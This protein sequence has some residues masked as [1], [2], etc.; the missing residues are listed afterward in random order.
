MSYGGS[1]SKRGEWL[2]MTPGKVLLGQPDRDEAAAKWLLETVGMPEK[3]YRKLHHEQGIQ[4]RGDRLRLVLFPYREYGIEP[5]WQELQVLYEDDFCLVVN[6]PAGLAVHPDNESRE[7][8]LNHVVAAYYEAE[9][10]HAA[11]RHIHRLDKDTTG[12]VLYA[13][14]EYAQLK[15]DEAMRE[16]KI[17]RMYAAIVQGRVSQELKRIDLPIGK[18]RYHA[19]RRR[20]SLTGQAAITHILS[21]E[22]YPKASLLHIRLETGR[23]HQIRVHLSHMGHPLL[24]DVLYGGPGTF[25]R[26]ALHGE[27]LLFHH[28]FTGES[29]EVP[30]PW[31]QDMMELRERIIEGANR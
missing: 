20:V 17:V 26:Q 2:E 15:L 29:I 14:N 3:L 21:A 31:P 18:D 4:W 30:A 28:P 10:I 23:T 7:T 9:G 12:P 25:A 6:K 1:W 22:A 13:K 19:S 11:V 16:K 27:R 8:T 5:R 24:G